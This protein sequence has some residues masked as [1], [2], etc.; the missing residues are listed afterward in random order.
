MSQDTGPVVGDKFADL[1]SATAEIDLRL[2]DFRPRTALRTAAHRIERP[3]FPAIDYHN[4]L[5]SMNPADVLAVMDECG[6]EHTVNITMQVGE[7][8]LRIMDRYRAAA[9]DRFS[10]I[11]PADRRKAVRRGGMILRR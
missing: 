3:R 8:A 11:H 6:V 1:M 2:G 4:H 7:R 9:P 10:P 5:D